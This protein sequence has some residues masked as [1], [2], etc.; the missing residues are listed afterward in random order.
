MRPAISRVLLSTIGI[1]TLAAGVFTSRLIFFVVTLGAGVLL[2]TSLST[3]RRPLT[4]A[5]DGFRNHVVHLRLWGVPTRERGLTP[6]APDG[7]RSQR[8]P[9][10]FFGTL[11]AV[12]A[13]VG[14]VTAA[15]VSRRDRGISARR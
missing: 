10:G 4:R 2:G 7:R 8:G 5:L 13:K 1:G 6:V 3:S 9:L 12:P 14:P 15:S 11:R